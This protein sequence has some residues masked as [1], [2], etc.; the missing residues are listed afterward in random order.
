[1]GTYFKEVMVQQKYIK[2]LRIFKKYIIFF[3]VII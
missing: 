3:K 2:K 1:M